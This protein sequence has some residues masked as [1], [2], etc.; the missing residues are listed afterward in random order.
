M[1]RSP[2]VATSI[3]SFILLGS[4]VACSSSDSSGAT[5]SPD[6]SA[7]GAGGTAGSSGGADGGLASSGGAS[8][9]GAAATSGGASGTGGLSSDASAGGAAGA[10]DGGPADAGSGDASCKKPERVALYIVLAQAGTM[11]DQLAGGTTKWDA[12]TQ[13]ITLFVND[14]SS[15]GL[16][17]GIQYFG[18]P[19]AVSCP[20][21]CTRDA[22]CGAFG[23]CD[24][25]FQ[26]CIGCAAGSDSCT[27]SDYATPDV[28]IGTLPTVGKSLID[29]MSA[30]SPSTRHALAP[31]IEGGVTY[32]RSYAQLH[33]N[34]ASAVVIVT[35]GLPTECTTDLS[36][37]G[38]LAAAGLPLV[39]TFIVTLGTSASTL[40]SVAQA[41][42]TGATLAVG[43]N[44]SVPQGVQQ[45][46]AQIA[47]SAAL[48]CVP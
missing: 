23:P 32:A 7:G 25:V 6:A 29:S 28:A 44:Q 34:E 31:A 46:L 4:V 36:A 20:A 42:G 10:S 26:I 38:A 3:A 15:G 14:T 5:S 21:T 16:G 19:I 8:T 47:G 39:H 48:S 11:S 41:G 12:V 27:A 43:L 18:L 2:L 13:G 45:A 33:P 1:L 22:D 40:D 9:G 37:I 24:T 17:I 35:D 30:H